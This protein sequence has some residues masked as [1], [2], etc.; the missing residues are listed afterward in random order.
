MESYFI[1]RKK[2]KMSQQ[3]KA[4]L[5]L[6]KYI[7]L[8]KMQRNGKKFW[9]PRMNDSGKLEYDMIQMP[10][11]EAQLWNHVGCITDEEKFRKG[12]LV[13]PDSIKV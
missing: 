5:P 6:P 2:D 10:A 9:P 11:A 7:V 4:R 12:M 3:R 8:K 1:N 13:H